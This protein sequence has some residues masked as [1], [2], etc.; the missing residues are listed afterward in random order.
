M[1][2]LRIKQ[3]NILLQLQMILRTADSINDTLI[4]SIELVNELEN[5]QSI[6]FL[7]S[8]GIQQLSEVLQLLGQLDPD[9]K[10][11][12]QVSMDVDRDHSDDD[13][14]APVI[15]NGQIVYPQR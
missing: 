10:P 4:K 8:E 6:Q 14:H 5:P 1:S 15:E 7:M 13:L 12:G 3:D 2:D 11:A 9:H